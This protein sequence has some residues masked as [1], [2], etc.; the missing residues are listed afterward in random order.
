MLR[1]QTDPGN[2]RSRTYRARAPPALLPRLGHRLAGGQ[3]HARDGAAYDGAGLDRARPCR[4]TLRADGPGACGARGALETSR[5]KGSVVGMRHGPGGK[6]PRG[7]GQR[8]LGKSTTLL[9]TISCREE[10]MALSSS[11]S[12][13][14]FL[15]IS[16]SASEI[17]RSVAKYFSK[18]SKL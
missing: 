16:V 9:S 14:Q 18:S 2:D 13:L 3:H 4:H 6:G 15:P 5:C 10:A 11:P 1:D 17:A 12:G 8:R 7:I